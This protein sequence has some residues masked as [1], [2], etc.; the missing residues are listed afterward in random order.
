M[1]AAVLDVRTLVVVSA[2]L[3][4]AGA[5]VLASVSR[6]TPYRGAPH[7][8]LAAASI[9]GGFL[10]L[11]LRG[12][13]P[14]WLSIVVANSLALAG[15]ILMWMGA[16]AFSTQRPV[17]LLWLAAG[18]AVFVPVMWVTTVFGT[19]AERTF[20]ILAFVAVPLYAAGVE[21]MRHGGR[22]RLV[23]RVLLALML[24][25]HATVSL[26]RLVTVPMVPTTSLFAGGWLPQLYFL[27]TALFVPVVCMLF[28]AMMGEKALRAVAAQSLFDAEAGHFNGAGF[29]MM[30]DK[31]LARGRREASPMTVLVAAFD[32]PLA[33]PGR[34]APAT[35]PPVHVERRFR[36]LCQ[37]VLREQDTL[38]RLEDGRYAVILPNTQLE[39]G[40]RIAHRLR[41]A[42]A[43]GAAR[44]EAAVSLSVGAAGAVSG[45][46]AGG[47]VLAA[48]AEAQERAARGGGNRVERAA[49]PVDLAF[50]MA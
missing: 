10:L 8:A 4:F 6:A 35:A 25:G 22:D 40:L 29:A 21:L 37:Q 13:I 32:P 30:L 46:A 42:L 16:R 43:G 26:A 38:G 9:G 28:A 27:E 36:A 18:L 3:A 11:G 39:D 15:C 23:T 12:A 17:S 45:V 1:G 33:G 20:V 19:L 2:M 14:D 31:E 5:V 41:A 47:N 24:F 34:A 49:M 7:W 48:A 44:G 50:G